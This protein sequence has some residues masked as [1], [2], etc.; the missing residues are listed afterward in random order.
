M[1]GAVWRG[2]KNIQLV[3]SPLSSPSS[4]QSLP[5][6]KC[7]HWLKQV[8]RVSFVYYFNKY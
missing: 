8:G 3:A 5:A 1:G 7:L 2:I 4:S 6:H